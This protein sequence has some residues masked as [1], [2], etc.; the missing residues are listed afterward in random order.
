MAGRDFSALL[1]DDTPATPQDFAKK[2]GPAAE[3]AA[4]RLGVSP[5]VLLAQFGLE[6]G[7]GK[8]V[9][10]GTNNLG[11][12]KGPGV[13]A[14]DSMTGS[15][16]QYRA[17][18]SPEDFANDFAELI[19]KRYG[20]A[21]GAGDDPV[22]FASA[23]KAGGYAEDPAYVMKVA[24]AHKALGR[25]GGRDFSALLA[26]ERPVAPQDYNRELDAL[27]KADRNAGAQRR[28][29]SMPALNTLMDFAHGA[30]TTGRGA[31][32]LINMVAPS[33]V[34][35][36]PEQSSLVS[37]G[38][39]GAKLLGNVADPAAAMVG[40]AAM[41]AL[42]YANVLGQGFLGGA[43]AVGQN[44]L[45]GAVPGAAIGTLNAAAE[46]GELG[47]GAVVGGGIGA[48][49]NV[50]LPPA[51]QK[52]GQFAARGWDMLR[53]RY[54]DIIA[55]RIIEQAAGND[56]QAIKALAQNSQ[57]GLT[58]AQATAPANNAQIAALGEFAAAAKPDTFNRIAQRQAQ[59]RIDALARV[60]GGGTQTAALAAQGAEKQALARATD[61]MREA[62]L[63]A[64]N[65]A[66]KGRKALD[67]DAL[68]SALASR[69]SAPG[70]RSNDLQVSVLNNV[71]EKLDAAKTAGGGVID[72]NDLYEIRKSAVNLAIEKL[73]P[74]DPAAQAKRAAQLLAEV[75]PMIDEAIEKAGG[76]GWRKYLNTFEQGMREIERRKMGAVML[77]QLKQ[78]PS[79]FVRTARGDN[80][81]AVRKVFGNEFDIAAAMGPKM[82]PITGAADDVARDLALSELAGKGNKALG[83]TIGSNYER[84]G[85][86]NLL[87]R[88]AML[89]NRVVKE[90]EG[91]VNVGAANA[92][93]KAM[94]SGKTLAEAINFVPLQDR[95]KVIQLLNNSPYAKAAALNAIIP[96]QE[97]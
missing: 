55:K 58:A 90:I 4:E 2:Y 92:L 11:N 47:T 37:P 44:L 15:R 17:Y 91:K 24:A 31:I 51:V 13:P 26:D 96:G 22:R 48:A 82:P 73:L 42:P 77:G 36:F 93:T 86:P 21:I 50:A 41:K 40:G 64:A 87:N 46:G 85:L 54:G 68:G 66:A 95:V 59:D 53:G 38:M 60:A 34:S 45:G 74:G 12:I 69:A 57:P 9:I 16:D 25:Q 81:D 84:F 80:P 3:V 28:R 70:T 18:A 83:Q 89:I 32:N 49:A 35:A 10:P 72:A 20:K 75:R 39:T 30:T 14:T 29:E 63:N 27:A 52:L 8:H 1:L 94:E 43:R 6:T 65:A 88:H 61:P 97:K 19:T 78:S 5:N 7:W 23:L 62:A 67:V 33:S 71:R 56:L 79:D 76:A